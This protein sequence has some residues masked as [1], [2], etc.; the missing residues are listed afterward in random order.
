MMEYF[1]SILMHHV[2]MNSRYIAHYDTIIQVTLKNVV[3][4]KK[5]TAVKEKTKQCD[6]Y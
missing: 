3:Q 5:I 4:G 6:I 2:V 1:A